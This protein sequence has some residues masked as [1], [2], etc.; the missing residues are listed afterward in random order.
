MGYRGGNIIEH[1]VYQ[2]GIYVDNSHKPQNHAL[3]IPG[4]F[5]IVSL[6]KRERE[7]PTV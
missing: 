2:W 1:D 6:E 4:R 7:Y 5:T 3:P